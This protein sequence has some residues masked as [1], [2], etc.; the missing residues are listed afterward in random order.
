MEEDTFAALFLK[1]S[2]IQN[3]KTGSLIRIWTPD[4]GIYYVLEGSVYIVRLLKNGTRSI[5]HV[6]GKNNLFFENRYFHHHTR[7][8]AIYAAAPTR[9]AYLPPETVD[10]LFASSLDFCHL[11]IR[12]M[13]E[14]TL[15]SGKHSVDSNR[16][17]P[18]TRMLAV[19]YEL[20]CGQE[21][22]RTSCVRITQA[23]LADF[24]GKHPVNTNITLKRLEEAGFLRLKRG[25]IELDLERMEEALSSEED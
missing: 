12:S 8:T 23:T 7:T 4:T 11:L 1:Q 15:R 22:G 14:K 5:L 17:C 25:A 6:L 18:E 3:W 19:L 21:G 9:T 10:R 13:S 16:L 24:V 2:T 20:A